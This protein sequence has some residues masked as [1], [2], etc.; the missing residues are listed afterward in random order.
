MLI[1]EVTF[2]TRSMFR[3]RAG[4]PRSDTSSAGL[5]AAPPSAT[6]HARRARSSSPR[7]SAISASTAEAPAMPPTKRYV[8][9]SQV[10]TGGL[11]TGRP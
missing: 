4:R 3:K 11:I 6:A 8:G 1:G 10:H 2:S 5:T 9:I 7:S